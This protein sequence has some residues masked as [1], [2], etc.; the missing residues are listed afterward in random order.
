MSVFPFTSRQSAFILTSIVFLFVI[1]FACS[2]SCWCVPFHLKTISLHLDRHICA[3]WERERVDDPPT[4][5]TSL[6][7]SFPSLF[8]AFYIFYLLNFVIQ[9]KY[10]RKVSKK[11]SETSSSTFL[12]FWLIWSHNLF[13]VISM[14]SYVD[15]NIYSSIDAE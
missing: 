11:S 14:Y 13:L 15:I 12:K 7:L 2:C 4:H 6:Y 8:V 5:L 10:N 1:V 9:Q 3:V